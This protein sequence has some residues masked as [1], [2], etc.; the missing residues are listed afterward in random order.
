MEKRVSV[1]ELRKV[2][3]RLARQV[4]KEVQRAEEIDR[5]SQEINSLGNQLRDLRNP[6]TI[7]SR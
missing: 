7:H 3:N 6:I 1:R 2:R 4:R 5:L